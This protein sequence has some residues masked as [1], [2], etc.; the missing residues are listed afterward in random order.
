VNGVSIRPT[1]VHHL[2]HDVRSRPDEPCV[3]FRR[4]GA[5]VTKTWRELARDAAAFA[6]AIQLQGIAKGDR[7]ALVSPNRYEWILCDLA[8]L[9]LGAV[10][11]TLH[12]SLTGPQQHFQ[13][14][15]SEAKLVIVAGAEQI[16]KLNAAPPLPA[17]VR[18]VSL[19]ATEAKLADQ[20]VPQLTTAA[21]NLADGAA[22]AWCETALATVAAGDLAAIL[23]TSGTTGDPKGVMLSHGNLAS[24]AEAIVAGFRGSQYDEHFRDRRL[25]L[26]PLSH[27]FARTC[28]LYCWLVSGSEIALAD[29]PQTAVADCAE[30]RPMIINAV[31]YFYDRAMRRLQESG[32]ADEPGILPM[33]LGGQVRHLCSGGAPLPDHVA[34]FFCDRGVRLTQGYGLTETSPVITMNT[35]DEHRHGTVGRPAP[36]IEVRIADDGEVITRGPHVMLGYWKRPAETAEVLRDG[37][38]HTGDLGAIDADGYL[39]ITGRK[40]ELLVTSGGKKVVPSVVEALLSADPLVRQVVVV[41]DGRKY[42]VALVV[43][44]IDRLAEAAREAGIATAADAMLRD[45]RV[46]AL[47][48]ARLKPRLAQ[49]SHYEQVQK[50]ALLDREFTVDREEL[51]LTMK[52]RR[53]QIVENFRDVIDRLYAGPVA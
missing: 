13:I 45:P 34:Q 16:E 2:V 46:V 52:L 7:I 38:F 5:V 47:V 30:F 6:A 21:T 8:I 32:M 9:S 33:V 14:V 26:L 40:K 15:D 18:V 39:R 42:L 44:D 25:N 41:G 29:S 50:I 27:I 43:P 19:D 28:D 24:N 1:L 12:N 4:S 51:T 11:V 53:E 20:A 31:P 48:E 35:P 10:N 22:Q 37:W 36:G 49:L 23:Y 3:F 17:G